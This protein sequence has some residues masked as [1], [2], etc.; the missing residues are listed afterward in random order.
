MSVDATVVVLHVSWVHQELEHFVY[1]GRL[2]IFDRPFAVIPALR[3]ASSE[4]DDRVRI[5]RRMRIGEAVARCVAVD[6]FL[7]A[8]RHLTFERALPHCVEVVTCADVDWSAA[9]V[10]VGRVRAGPMLY[11]NVGL[12]DRRVHRWNEPRG[13]V[14]RYHGLSVVSLAEALAAKTARMATAIMHVGLPLLVRKDVDPR[15]RKWILPMPFD[16]T[17]RTVP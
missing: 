15:N 2:V 13:L 6:A 17:D 5:S 1:Q 3:W 12:C 4:Y 16:I 10:P 8:G 14:P 11:K 7:A 9:H